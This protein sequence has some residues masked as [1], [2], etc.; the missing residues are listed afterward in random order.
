[1]TVGS[2]VGTGGTLSG[3]AT[4]PIML[5]VGSDNTSTTYAGNIVDGSTGSLA[6][7]KTG[8]GTLTL[9]GTNTYS[10]GTSVLNGT[11]AVAS[12][13]SLGSGPVSITALSTLSYSANTS[14]NKSFTLGGGTLS[15]NGGATLTL[16]GSTIISG[17][18]G[19]SGTFAT[20]A[21]SGARFGNATS[22][23][24]VTITSNNGGDQ[25]VNFTNGGALTVAPN[26]VGT[27]LTGVT[28]QGSGAITIGAVRQR[29]CVRLRVLRHTDD[30]PCRRRQ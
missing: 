10:G 7:T 22:L 28:N 13:G 11:L 1:M 9:T 2:L 14:T 3:N 26:I 30:K 6:L 25:F 21:T 12:D 20:S 8:T 4:T 15:V 5:T 17:F 27:T 19:G 29:Q 23:P 18:L 16:N 24:S